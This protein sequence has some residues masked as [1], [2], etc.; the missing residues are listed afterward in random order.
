MYFI[1]QWLYSPLLGPALFFSFIILFTQSLGLL[2][3]VISSSQ[4]RYLYTGQHRHTIN[5]HTDIHAMN[6]I[7]THD[8][9]VQESE[10]SSCLRPRGHCDRLI[11]LNF[12]HRHQ[13]IKHDTLKQ[14][15]DLSFVSYYG[16]LSFKVLTFDNLLL[17]LLTELSPSWG[18]ANCAAPQ[19]LPSILWNPNI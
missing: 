1:H 3:W 14:K 19:E 12:T 15:T 11:Q 2:G 5:T 13:N 6:R 17:Y 9:R 16:L 18:A 7:R 10:N 8:P 4:V